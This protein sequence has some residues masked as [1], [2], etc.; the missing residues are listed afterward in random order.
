VACIIVCLSWIFEIRIE[1][2]FILRISRQIY[3]GKAEEMERKRKKRGHM[4]VSV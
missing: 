2:L 4:A 3:T 1:F